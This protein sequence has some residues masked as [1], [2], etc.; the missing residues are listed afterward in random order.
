MAIEKPAYDGQ[1]RVSNELRKEGKFI[2]PAGIRCVWQR[3][4][5]ETF[6]KRLKAL[7]TKMAQENLILPLRSG[8]YII[9]LLTC[10]TVGLSLY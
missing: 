3:H 1:L 9:A 2:S 5:L 10:R 4:D 8:C 7:E 6:N